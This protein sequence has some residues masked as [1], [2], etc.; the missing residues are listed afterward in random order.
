[1]KSIFLLLFFSI[2]LTNCGGYLGSPATN[3][4]ASSSEMHVWNPPDEEKLSIRRANQEHLDHLTSEIERLFFNHA[5]LLQQES[6]MDQIIRKK[7]SE[8]TKTESEFSDQIEKQLQRNKKMQADL[9]EIQVK[10]NSQKEKI[11]KLSEIKP[12]II[13]STKDY[14]YAMKA[15]SRR[16]YKTSI[17]FFKKLLSQNPP[18]FL[19]DNIHFGIGSSFFRLKNYQKAKTHF[20]KII[21]NFKMGDK[22]FNSY[23]MLGIIHNL[24]GEKSRALYML[25]E[26]LKNNPPEKIKTFLRSLIKNINENAGY[27]SN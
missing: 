16:N 2:F 4:S 9:N 23:A 5:S 22:R 3:W 10:Y 15:F 24:K 11:S 14:N 17:Y 1:M 7:D 13:F 18:K 6:T 20:Q 21:D 12:P 19:K 27:A 25:D 26:A 8:I